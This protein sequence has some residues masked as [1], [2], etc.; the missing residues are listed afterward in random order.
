MLILLGRRGDE[1]AAGPSERTSET[2]VTRSAGPAPLLIAFGLLTLGSLAQYRTP[3]TGEIVVTYPPLAGLPS[4]HVGGWPAPNV[5]L[6]A[7]VL[8]V[9]GGVSRRRAMRAA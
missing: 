4:S 6:S 8:L 7:V 5:V 9:G 3:A 1:V 2:R